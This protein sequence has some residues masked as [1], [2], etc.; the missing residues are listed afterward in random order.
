[1][2]FRAEGTPVNIVLGDLDV[3]WMMQISSELAVNPKIR[4]V[5]FAN[6]GEALIERTASMAADAV[7]VNYSMPDMTAMDIV[8]RL[9]ED[10][11]GTAVFVMSGAL[12]AQ[13]V[14]SA[15][16]TGVVEVFDRNSYIS[17]EIAR[18]I[19]E[20][21]DNLRKEWSEVANSHGITEKGVGPMGLFKKEKEKEKETLLRTVTQ[22][23]ILTHSPKGGV[24]KSTIAT[25]L[26]AAIKASPVLSG[27]KICLLDF[28]CEFGNLSTIWDIPPNL[29]YTRNITQWANIPESISASDVDNLLTPT[30]SGVMILPAPVNPAVAAK[31]NIE[32]ADKVLR[33]L[34]RYYSIIVIDGGPKI[35]E[36]VDAAMQH[37]THILLI[38]NP[39]GQSAE[40][41]NRVVSFLSPDPNYPEKP[42]FSSLLNKMFLVVNRIRG[43]K[44]ELSPG[45]VAEIVGRP[46]I[47][48]IPEDD[49]VPLALH[50]GN[51]KQAVEYIPDS[52]FA[53]AI[54]R[55]ANDVTG[56]YPMNLT[57]GRTKTAKPR[58]KKRKLFGFLPI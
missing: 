9:S 15:K 19:V 36:A 28:D 53:I 56:A 23:V 40:N 44:A 54:K 22:S 37:A 38:A 14:M 42:D 1:M 30:K 34:K 39:E 35:Q 18:K 29:A 26:A 31:V 50:E 13:L 43:G 17:S 21:V 10:S 46:V 8:K 57:S 32:L 2:E 47:G 5:G 49:V 4:V 58:R 24:G 52:P 33:I 11:P 7:L 16:S 48:E 25:N 20:H 51:G 27:A 12:S 55:L 41:L 6:S 3:N 45:Q